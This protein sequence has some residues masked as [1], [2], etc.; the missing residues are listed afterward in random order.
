MVIFFRLLF[1]QFRQSVLVLLILLFGLMTGALALEMDKITFEKN[2]FRLVEVDLEEDKLQLF[3]QDDKG[4][5][6]GSFSGLSQYLA[7]KNQTLL[8]A[9]NSGIY[10][11]DYTPLGLHIEQG[12]WLAPLNKV[13]SNAGLGNFALLPNGVFYLDKSSSAALMTTETFQMEHHAQYQTKQGQM[14]PWYATQSGP[15]LLTDGIY[16]PR[17]IKG[18]TSY[19]IRSGVCVQGS[20]VY[21]VV[22]E[23]VVNFYTFARFFKEQLACREAL[24]LDGTLA[25]LY[26]NGRTYGAPFWQ[27]KPLV[28]IWGVIKAR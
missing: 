9:I 26:Y 3:W 20:L 12:E 21:F 13:R 24:Y 27:T 10:T 17:L 28:G 19:K 5:A 22:T 7:H 16:N 1:G 14:T 18:S 23:T 6:F 4:E 25:K 11:T 2:Q 8:F 15:M